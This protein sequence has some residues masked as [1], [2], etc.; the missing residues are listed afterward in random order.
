MNS[1]EIIETP[2]WDL[3]EKGRN[4]HR[5]M[6]I[7]VDTDRN[8]RF[9]NGNQWEGANL[10]DIEPVQKN[11]IK[12]IVKY[13]TSVIHANLYALSFRSENYDTE[14]FQTEAKHYCKILNGYAARTWEKESMDK[15]GR[16][17]TK[18]AAIN[19]EGIMYVTY[20]KESQMP[21]CEVVDKPDVYYGNENTEDIQSQPYILIR[22]RMPV[23][24]AIDL[25]LREGLSKKDT[26][27]I[28]GD[29]DT[30]EQSGDAA[31]HEVNDAVTVV[32]KLYKENGTVHYSI[33]TRYQ[34]ITEGQDTGLSLYPVAHFIW[35]TKKGSARGEGEIRWIIPT[36]IEVNRNEVRR[37]LAVKHQAFP[38]TMYSKNMISNPG[39]LNKVG[40][41]IEVDGLVDDV[42]K[43]IG[44][45]PPVQMSSDVKQLHDDLIQITRELAGA[46]D[47]A[48]GTV[49]PE[50]ASGKAILTVLRA[51]EQPVND[52]KEGYKSFVEDIGKIWIDMFVTHSTEGLKIPEKKTDAS[53][54]EYYEIVTI[55]HSVM[56]ELRASVKVD[57]T[58]KSVYDKFA[59]EQVL[60]NI[61]LQGWLNPQH[62]PALRA[63]AETLDDDSTAPKLKIL[64]LCD[65]V[66]ETQRQIADI[67]ARAQIMSQRAEQFF[68]A[69]PSAQAQQISDAE[70]MMAN[71]GI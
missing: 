22:R 71:Q 51:S 39:D 45:L 69:D 11:F 63:F 42:K 44:T 54:G 52:Q 62:I 7:Y 64:E 47:V 41:A 17:V 70:M 3:Y 50:S 24:N 37:V 59:Q 65:R 6:G 38:K 46:G 57:V 49:D 67:S 43:A 25:A 33:S 29:N 15:K 4:F 48:T 36:Q 18:D 1:K 27:N 8:Y 30:F 68:T 35:E 28:I 53:G 34:I 16:A 10:G 2:I 61:F 19:G 13:K 21:V 60:E 31:K 12:P 32:Y 20:D 66:E 55:P 56:R 9:Y 23:V 58:P 14:L 26:K 40:V 5:L